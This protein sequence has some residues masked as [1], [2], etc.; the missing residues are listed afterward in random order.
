[1]RASLAASMLTVLG[2]AAV[3]APPAADGD[4]RQAAL[5]RRLAEVAAG[6]Q[7]CFVV[8]DARDGRTLRVHEAECRRPLPPCSTFKVFNSLAGL[9]SGVVK[10]ETT[11]FAWDHTPQPR[12]EWEKDHTLATAVRDS[13]VWYFQ[14]VAAG[15]GAKA[16]QGYLDAVG[17]G[18]RDISGGLTRFWLG[19]SLKISPDE[20]V[21]FLRRLYRD[22]LPFDRRN[23]DIVR[24]ILVQEEK[25]GVT[26]SGKTGSCEAGGSDRA[27]WFVG[28]QASATREYIFAT[29]IVGP[30]RDEPFGQGPDG[31]HAREISRAMLS[32]LPPR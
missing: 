20:Q 8:Y 11:L 16:M 29:R 31:F 15:V 1:M 21:A 18:N 3:P 9:Q 2:A 17:Y 27:G 23:T 24:R 28:R 13:V 7:S 19:S 32:V 30:S 22:D 26:F 14:R 25:D 12:P 5:E 6:Y 4:P 10:D